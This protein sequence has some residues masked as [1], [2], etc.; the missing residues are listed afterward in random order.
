M[1]DWYAVYYP[2]FDRKRFDELAK[3]LDLDTGRKIHTLSKGM[4]RP[5]IHAS[6]RL[7]GHKV[8]FL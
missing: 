1:A 2:K 3:R 8:S 5:G 6:G 4:K 7:R